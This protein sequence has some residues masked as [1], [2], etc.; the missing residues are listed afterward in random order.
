M[1]PWS[2]PSSAVAAQGRGGL[3]VQLEPFSGCWEG[4][5]VGSKPGGQEMEPGTFPA[6]H[7]EPIR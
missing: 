4:Q 2:E 6:L 1:G 5:D 3:I 7:V